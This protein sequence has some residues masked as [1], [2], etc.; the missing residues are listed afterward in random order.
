MPIGPI[1]RPPGAEGSL[2]ANLADRIIMRVLSLVAMV[3]GAIP[4]IGHPTIERLRQDS[5][6]RW[7]VTP[8]DP[9]SCA[10]AIQ[11]AV[12]SEAD[13][14][15]EAALSGVDPARLDALVGLAGNPPGPAELVDQW[16]RGLLDDA[17]LERG[18]RQGRTKNEWLGFY[19]ALRHLPISVGDLVNAAVQNHLPRD[20]AA[21]RAD[22]LG[23]TAA[24]FATLYENAGA[25][26]G[27]M[28]VLHLWNRG[29]L[30]EAEVDQAIRESR[31]KD[32][33]LP[34]IKRL[35]EYLPPPRTV[36]T[37]LAHG[38]IT[39]A[40]A[41]DLF[42]RN[43]LTAE[44]ADA[45]AASA[46]HAKAA[47]HKELA[48]GQVTSLYA[49]RLISRADATADLL[50][51]GYAAAEAELLLDLAD[52]RARQKVRTQAVNRVRTLFVGR[53]IDRATAESDLAKVG[54]D[55]S[56]VGDLLPLWEIEQATPTRS[57][58]EAQVMKAWSD[59]VISE[60]DARGRLAGLGYAPADVDVLARTYGP[61][62]AGG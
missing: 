6:T 2:S 51:I 8:I 1:V 40:Q 43:G 26:P 29:E 47:T 59:G 38:A 41:V 23:I 3:A 36:T 32:K 9:A 61:A 22:G 44:L 16:R 53:R 28:E 5:L 10:D 58:T 35:A 13:W 18:I 49:D 15:G 12:L 17:G 31:L 54:L 52:A 20:Q 42:R 25:P 21:A 7:P 4:A 33:Y 48:T 62:P 24:D 50:R 34:G 39:R 14:R 11:R 55:A 57:L 27:V 37:L 19:R 60:A 46:V 30:S 56:Q 45:Y